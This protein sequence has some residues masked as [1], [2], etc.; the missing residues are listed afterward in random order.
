MDIRD[1]AR[2]AGYSVGTVSRVLND[3]PGVS[4]RARERV[5]E[6]VREMG[7]E[8][9]ANAR[10]LKMRGRASFAIMVKGMQNMLFN[11]I[12]EKAEGLFAAADEEARIH[13]VDEDADEVAR[14]IHLDRIRHPKGFLFL[15]GDPN[16]FRAGFEQISVPCV[17]LTNT[18]EEWGLRGLSSFS[19]ND[20]E[21]AGCVIDYLWECGH[22]RIGIIGGDREVSEVS[23]HRLDGVVCAFERHGA[24]FD[25]ERCYEP[26]RF[27]MG[28]GYH[29]AMRLLER[30][31][32]L[33]AVFAFGDVIALGVQRAISDRGF[34]VPADIS[35]V[36]FDGVDV[37]QYSVPR[38]TT[39]RQ[40]A[41]LL[42]RKGVE[43]LLA[44]VRDGGAEGVHESVPFRLL[45]RESV[46]SLRPAATAG[47]KGGE[48]S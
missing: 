15:G 16:N 45:R 23:S 32:D 46:L 2:L 14:A 34:R 9:N 28:D 31:D 41:G 44:A 29:A 12:I 43:A 39:V 37:S 40:D 48:R 19:T 7:Y 18:A 25:A 6:V 17:L 22:R 30:A 47:A 4:D 21:A 3:H 26:C 36:G 20:A 35:L 13:F 5:L 10:H 33:T 11:D 42:A 27:S 1:I 38:L 8:P 24:T